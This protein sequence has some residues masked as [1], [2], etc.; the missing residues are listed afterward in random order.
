MVPV[1]NVARLPPVRKLKPRE[2]VSPIMGL[3]NSIGTPSSSDAII[4]MEA[5]DPPISGVPSVSPTVPSSL[6]VMDELVSPPILNQ[7]PE[8]TPRAW[9]GPSGA[10]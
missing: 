4:A 2:L 7:K 8:A 1:E 3:I 5:R 6:I 9:F 10:E